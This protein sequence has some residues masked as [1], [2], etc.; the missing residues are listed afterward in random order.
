MSE[1]NKEWHFTIEAYC[2]EHYIPIPQK[3]PKLKDGRIQ[4][5]PF[6]RMNNIFKFRCPIC[7][8]KI[9]VSTEALDAD[10]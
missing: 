2:Y 4:M 1:S 9:K 6:S 10:P 8:K 5:I 7:K 3:I